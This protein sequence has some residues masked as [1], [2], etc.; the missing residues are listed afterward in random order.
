MGALGDATAPQQRP[1]PRGDHRCGVGT[2]GCT[3]RRPRIRGGNAAS[4]DHPN[5]L[6]RRSRGPS[7]GCCRR[8]RRCCG[9]EPVQRSPTQRD[10]A[11]TQRRNGGSGGSAESS[12]IVNTWLPAWSNTYTTPRGGPT[13]VSAVSVSSTWM[14]PASS[15]ATLVGWRKAGE[16][17]R[18]RVTGDDQL[19]VALRI[20]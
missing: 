2:S 19:L 8:D 11:Q 12:E 1:I 14:R 6:V 7:S 20:A 18:C 3:E 13:G 16:R 15:T 5:G 17:T 9:G 4:A 10:E